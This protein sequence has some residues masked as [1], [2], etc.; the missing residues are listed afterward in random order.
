MY[1]TVFEEIRDGLQ[2]AD[3]LAARPVLGLWEEWLELVMGRSRRELALPEGVILYAVR[4][5]LRGLSVREEKVRRREGG[6]RIRIVPG[7]RAT[8][9]SLSEQQ[10][11]RLV[12]RVYED[13]Q[14]FTAAQE[15]GFLG[16]MG[17]P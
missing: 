17:D 11:G 12:S 9:L 3:R 4:Q 7:R 8:W 14:R 6:H 2:G 5:T 1:D 10:L 13:T 16:R 15:L